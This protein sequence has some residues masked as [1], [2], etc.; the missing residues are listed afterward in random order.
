MVSKQQRLNAVRLCAKSVRFIRSLQRHV[1]IGGEE[2][3]RARAV[4]ALTLIDEYLDGE[5][6]KKIQEFNNNG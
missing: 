5:F 4:Y 2:F 3:T 6:L 1:Q